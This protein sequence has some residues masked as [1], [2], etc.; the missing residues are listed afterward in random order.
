MS[1]RPISAPSVCEG[2]K[3]TR[4]GEDQVFKTKIQ[5]LIP[6]IEFIAAQKLSFSSKLPQFSINFKFRANLAEN[7]NSSI[8]ETI[9][10]FCSSL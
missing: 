5:I 4:L 8:F 10:G 6:L 9:F 3:L 7:S 2:A 1:F